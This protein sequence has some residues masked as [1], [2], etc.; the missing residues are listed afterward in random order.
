MQLPPASRSRLHLTPTPPALSPN[1]THPRPHAP[2]TRLPASDAVSQ[3]APAAV[4]GPRL[5][6]AG[7]TARHGGGG[8]R[9][10]GEEEGE[11]EGEGEQEE[12]GEGGR[13]R[14]AEGKSTIE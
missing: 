14:E 12:K 2:P 4:A 5:H 8:A 13:R 7:T 1:P 10:G 6:G 11:G 9:Q 3:S